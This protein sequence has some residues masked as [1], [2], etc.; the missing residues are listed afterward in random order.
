MSDRARGDLKQTELGE[1]PEE[2]EVR[3]IKGVADVKGGKRLPKGHK[4]SDKPTSYPYIRVVDFRDGSVD[5]SNL[6]YL[7]PE[8]YDRIK[9]YTISGDDVYISIAGTIGLVGV[10]PSELDGANLTEN[11]AKIVIRSKSQLDRFFLAHYLSSPNGQHWIQRVTTKSTQPK[12]ALMR[13]EQIPLPVPPLPEQRW[14]TGVLRLVDETI[15]RTNRLIEQYQRLKKLALRHLLTKGIGHTRFKQTELGELPEKWEV[16]VIGD[17]AERVTKGTTPTTYGYKYE[18]SGVLFLRAEN[19]SDR[20]YVEGGERK[21]IS[22]ETNAYL[23]RSQLQDQDILFTIAGT[24]GRSAIVNRSILP[25]NINQ[26]IAVIRLQ[27]DDIDPQFIKNVLLGTK[28]QS[29]V[30]LLAVQLAQA[31]LSLKQVSDLL[32]PFPPFHEQRQIAE[33]L[34]KLDALI[35]NE[36][37][38]AESLGKLKRLWMNQ[39]LRGKMRVPPE[40]E[41]ILKEVLPSAR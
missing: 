5:T 25:A 16:V 9:R 7:T 24:I 4:F 1:L 28:V 29:Q 23:S 13:I 11:A 30:R 41:E 3:L 32:I 18:K 22:A 10:I 26:A 19:I 33:H 12:L 34:Q 8:D 35:D 36:R 27:K 17:I 2:W 6:Q 38:Y 39:L 31:N 15:D 14:I 37:R 20:G 40:A 21:F